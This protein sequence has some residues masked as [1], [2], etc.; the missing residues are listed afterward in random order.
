MFLIFRGWLLCELAIVIYETATISVTVG[1]QLA[2]RRHATILSS[3]LFVHIL[4]ASLKHTL[5]L[6]SPPSLCFSAYWHCSTLQISGV[7]TVPPSTVFLLSPWLIFYGN[8]LHSGEIEVLRLIGRHAI[9][10]TVT[11]HGIVRAYRRTSG[12]YRAWAH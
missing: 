11:L 2:L 7:A 8:W 9:L 5:H 12:V 6:G 10:S 3:C 1:Y 4:C